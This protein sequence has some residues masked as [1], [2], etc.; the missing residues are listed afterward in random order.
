MYADPTAS[1]LDAPA[2][3]RPDRWDFLCFFPPRRFAAM[4]FLML[5]RAA[6]RCFMVVMSIPRKIRP[7]SR[8]GK[9]IPV[10]MRMVR[11]H[12]IEPREPGTWNQLGTNS[13]PHRGH[14][15]TGKGPAEPVERARRAVGGEAES[16][17]E[18]E[19]FAARAAFRRA[20]NWGC[21]LP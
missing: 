20:R 17:L 13:C 21:F 3:D 16:G 7:R 1:L 4:A 15:T 9:G 5:R 18:W 2:E 14:C 8:D 10:G 11:S 6:A 19:A 12:A